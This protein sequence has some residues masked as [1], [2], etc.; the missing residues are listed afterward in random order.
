MRISGENI[1]NIAIVGHSLVKGKPQIF[2]RFPHIGHSVT[3]LLRNSYAIDTIRGFLY[4][5]NEIL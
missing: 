3:D 5:V 2:P 1:R 4:N